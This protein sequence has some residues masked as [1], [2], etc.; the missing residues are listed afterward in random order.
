MTEAGATHTMRQ[1]VN[2]ITDAITPQLIACRRDFHRFAETGWTEFH[3]ASL[4]A[5]RLAE[6]GCE[7]QVGQQVLDPE[8]RMGVPD[9]AVLEACDTSAREGKW[10]KVP[11]I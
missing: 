8:E 9:Q 1:S 4:V 11:K 7:V 2:A 5:R 6:L 3:T 10:A